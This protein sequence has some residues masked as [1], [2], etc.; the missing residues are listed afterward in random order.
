MEKE[1]KKVVMRVECYQCRTRKVLFHS[2][3]TQVY[4]ETSGKRKN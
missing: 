1:T 4:G 2:T 3:K